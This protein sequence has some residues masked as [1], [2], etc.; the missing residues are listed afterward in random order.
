M[1]NGSLCKHPVIVLNKTSYLCVRHA[2]SFITSYFWARQRHARNIT[3]SYKRHRDM[4]EASSRPLLRAE[5]F[6]SIGEH[7]IDGWSVIPE[8]RAES[9]VERG[10]R[11]SKATSQQM[12]K[13]I[14]KKIGKFRPKKKKKGEIFNRREKLQKN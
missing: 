6:V 1:A 10:D 4:Q 5:I 8:A 9:R 13:K 3:M 2:R 14:K 12:T 11:E 7:C